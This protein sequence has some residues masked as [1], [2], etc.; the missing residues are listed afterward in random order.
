MKVGTPPAC[1]VININDDI[2]PSSL[3]N[4]LGLPGTLALNAIYKPDVINSTADRVG[5]G[6]ELAFAPSLVKA[7]TDITSKIKNPLLRK[8]A[9]IG[10]TINP[11]YAMRAATIAQPLGSERGEGGYEIL[12]SKGELIYS[13][14]EGMGDSA[15]CNAEN[16]VD[17]FVRGDIADELGIDISGKNKIE[18]DKLI[19]ENAK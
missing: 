2:D 5:V 18:I 14:W 3:L 12:N 8:A 19:E 4:Y 1:P 17:W 7:A 10:S 13:D 15:T 6:A 16:E 11:K 9:E